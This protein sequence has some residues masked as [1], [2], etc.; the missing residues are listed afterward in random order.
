[1]T[2]AEEINALVADVDQAQREYCEARDRLEALRTKLL[3]LLCGEPSGNE[4]N[5]QEQMREQQTREV[6][7][8]ML[9]LGIE[10]DDPE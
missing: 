7:S 9:A 8:D 6:R 2:R 10:E 5:L 4:A 1:M 3:W